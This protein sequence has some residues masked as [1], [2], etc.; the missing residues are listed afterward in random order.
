MRLRH[1]H[2][3]E[4]K[5]RGILRLESHLLQ[6][7][8]ALETFHAAFDEEQAETVTLLGVS[9]RDND[10]EVADLP[11]RDVSL[12]PVQQPVIAFVLGARLDARE[13]AARARLG[14][15]DAEYRLAA[16]TFRKDAGFLFLG[17]E[18]SYVGRDEPRVQRHEEP[19]LTV[20]AVLL[21]QDLLVPKILDTRAAI[22]RIGPDQQIPLLTSLAEGR[23]IDISLLAPALA[24]RPDLLLKETACTFAE[25]FVLRFEDGAMHGLPPV[26]GD[27]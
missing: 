15:R 4:E 26:T 22:L 24:I 18:R 16:R 12:R 23:R 14:H 9:A 2:I 11:I 3:G 27:G 17:A 6:V 7:A 21:D 8:S 13:I 5:L 25:L 19:T 1:L 10:E 20:Q